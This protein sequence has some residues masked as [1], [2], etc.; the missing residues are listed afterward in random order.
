MTKKN[1]AEKLAAL[2]GVSQA[3]AL[4]AI[5]MVI[6]G[7]RD[8]I[9]EGNTVTFRGF[10]NFQKVLSGKR[11]G[12]NLKTGERVVIPEKSRVKFKSYMELENETNSTEE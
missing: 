5:N 1:L 10:G 3:E 11:S 7:T 6:D 8:A 12:R 9:L 4:R 2:N